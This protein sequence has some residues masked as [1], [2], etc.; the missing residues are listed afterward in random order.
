MGNVADE[1]ATDIR[2]EHARAGLD[3]Y[4]DVLSAWR[5]RYEDDDLPASFHW[6]K[7]VISGGDWRKVK[8]GWL[9]YGCDKKLFG[10]YFADGKLHFRATVCRPAK[11]PMT[12]KEFRQLATDNGVSLPS[13]H[14][15][16]YLDIRREYEQE[17]ADYLVWLRD[18]Y[19]KWKQQREREVPRG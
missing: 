9:P 17:Q 3:A 19:P 5:R 14:A 11:W 6:I 10:W 15:T 13:R 7:R 2:L 1:I 4:I 8:E 16:L 18:E 12:R